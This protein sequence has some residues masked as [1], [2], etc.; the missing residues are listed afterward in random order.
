MMEMWDWCEMQ[1][2]EWLITECC[3][4][5]NTKQVLIDFSEHIS[6]TA[7]GSSVTVWEHPV[8]SDLILFALSNLLRWIEFP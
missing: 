4:L 2:K 7:E 5:S 3:Y 6:V 1:K 8:S